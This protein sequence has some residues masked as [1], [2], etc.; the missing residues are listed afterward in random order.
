[1]EKV[2]KEEGVISWSRDQ[3]QMLDLATQRLVTLVRKTPEQNL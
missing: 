1:M 2:C 3:A